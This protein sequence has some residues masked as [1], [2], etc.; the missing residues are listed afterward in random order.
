VNKSK[1]ISAVLKKYGI[2]NDK[3]LVE[4]LD[5]AYYQDED[6]I[7]KR[8]N[9][10]Q[11]DELADDEEETDASVNGWEE[12]EEIDEEYE[13]AKCGTKLGDSY[14]FVKGDKVC[15]ECVQDAIDNIMIGD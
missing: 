14:M 9:R 6:Q 13:C 15:N 4:L 10:R 5:I 3:L 1:E 7:I 2:V 11:W 12:E 8:L